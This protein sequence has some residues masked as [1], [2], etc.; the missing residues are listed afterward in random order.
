MNQSKV[1]PTDCLQTLSEFLS[2]FYIVWGWRG[3]K[4]TEHSVSAGPAENV[5]VFGI[6]A[7]NKSVI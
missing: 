3:N 5:R 4:V 6:S 1:I 7:E 2:V